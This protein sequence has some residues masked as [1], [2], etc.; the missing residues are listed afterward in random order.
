MLYFFC[1]NKHSEIVVPFRFCDIQES[2][3]ENYVVRMSKVQ[4]KSSISVTVVMGQWHKD[5]DEG[6][7]MSILCV[8]VVKDGVIKYLVRCEG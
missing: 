4:G 8:S 7:A 1:T 2:M 5:S 3:S 6:N